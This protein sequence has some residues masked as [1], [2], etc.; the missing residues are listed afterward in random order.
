[1]VCPRKL[2]EPVFIF[3]FLLTA[4]FFNMAVAFAFAD[5]KTPQE[6]AD[7][8]IALNIPRGTAGEGEKFTL[9]TP[10]VI[11]QNELSSGKDIEFVR[12]L[13]TSQKGSA[14]IYSLKECID[15]A[16]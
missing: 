9:G 6:P 11:P 2:K 8:R 7:K 12:G 14:I 16:I 15:I 4:L 13:N 5:S 3:S 10:L 1:M